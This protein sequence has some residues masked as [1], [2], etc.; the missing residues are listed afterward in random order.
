MSLFPKKK[1]SIP[2]R[3]LK[4]NTEHVG[5]TKKYRNVQPRLTTTNQELRTI[6][7]QGS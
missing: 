4:S 7:T 1:W 6:N 3:N 5:E 2:L